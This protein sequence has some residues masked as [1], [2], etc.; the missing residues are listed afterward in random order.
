MAD[1]QKAPKKIVD[2]T[3]IS[4]VRPYNNERRNSLENHL[5]HRPDR[6]EL[7][8]SMRFA[9]FDAAPCS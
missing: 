7:I 9:Q 3:P 5:K 6:S 4:P 1:E 8:E 2:D